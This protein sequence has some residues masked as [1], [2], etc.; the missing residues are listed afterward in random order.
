MLMVPRDNL[1]RLV[2]ALPESELERAERVLEELRQVAEPP[3]RPLEDAP[4][5]DESETAEE[6]AAVEEARSDVGAGRV[7]SHDEAKRRWGL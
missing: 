5:D 3:Y 2:D 1:H 6:K 4:L 7:I